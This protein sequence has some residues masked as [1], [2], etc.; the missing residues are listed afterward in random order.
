MRTTIVPSGRAP[1]QQVL[2]LE[3]RP[4]KPFVVNA[5]C[6]PDG[7]MCLDLS[8]KDFLRLGD[9]TQLKGSI[10][11]VLLKLL[12]DQTVIWVSA[13]QMNFKFVIRKWDMQFC[14]SAIWKHCLKMRENNACLEGCGYDAAA[15]AAAAVGL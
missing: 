12:F 15:A 6:L 8:H 5:G 9:S 10:D 3:N 1:E 4:I 13:N 7:L 2:S 14:F 11:C